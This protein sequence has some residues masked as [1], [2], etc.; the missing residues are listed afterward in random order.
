MA[1][2]GRTNGARQSRVT[3]IGFLSGRSIRSYMGTCVRSDHDSRAAPQTASPVYGTK[4]FS[5]VRRRNCIE[6][7]WPCPEYVL[8]N[9]NLLS[10]A[11]TWPGIC[12]RLGGLVA[13]DP[14]DETPHTHVRE[15]SVR[16][17]W[18][19]VCERKSQL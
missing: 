18:F 15:G 12:G 2:I 16:L 17:P 19:S 7:L 10:Q 8:E 4:N 3:L 13:A 1:R 6:Q 14:S 5:S 11:Q 9:V